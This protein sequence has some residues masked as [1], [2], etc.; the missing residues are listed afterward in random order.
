MLIK[1]KTVQF[2]TMNCEYS[3]YVNKQLTYSTWNATGIMSSAS[4]LNEFLS[5]NNVDLIGISEHW[6]YRHDL[7]FLDCINNKYTSFAISDPDLDLPSNRRVGKGGVGIMWK[8]QLSHMISPL[9]IK[10]QYIMGVVLTLNPD[11]RIYVFQ[12]YIP[13]KN[14]IMAKYRLSIEEVENVL[15]IYREK[16]KLVI[17]GDFNTE[18]PSRSEVADRF[19]FDTRGKLLTDSLLFFDIVPVNTLEFCQGAEYS[20]VPY[21]CAR[22]TLIDYIFIQR[23]EICDVSSCQILDDNA[24]NVST[25]R[26]IICSIRYNH[27]HEMNKSPPCSSI[28]WR[29]VKQCSIDNYKK[30]IENDKLL[31]EISNSEIILYSDIDDVYKI[32]VD[33][34]TTANKTLIPKPRYKPY[35]KPYWNKTLSVLHKN[36]IYKRNKWLNENRPRGAQFKSYAEYKQTKSEFR[37]RHR[38][39]VVDYMKSMEAELDKSAEIDSN[40]FWKIVNKRRKK[41]TTTHIHQLIFNSNSC[42]T[43]E[44]INNGWKNISVYF[45]P[46]QIL[47]RLI[48]NIWITH[49][50]SF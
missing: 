34:I 31:Q 35:I 39:C 6:L 48:R 4:Y 32:I 20:N 17:M 26:P 12:V 9:E 15:S 27:G 3:P 36:M 47:I 19:S 42:K 37:R 28:N 14:H 21:N 23:S 50:R 45:I 49:R 8:K 16:G 7:H 43:P 24:L 40:A 13:C 11:V 44:S 46:N 22:E 1:Y 38:E 2:V 30:F 10:S 41:S 18:L 25:H 5:V 33:T 29:N